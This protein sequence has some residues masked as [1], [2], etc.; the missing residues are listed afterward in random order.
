MTTDPTNNPL[1]TPAFLDIVTNGWASLDNPHRV[2][3]FVRK[4]RRPRGGVN[5]GEM[6]QLTDGRGK[7]WDVA[8]SNE[9]LE[10]GGSYLDPQA[11]SSLG[12]QDGG[13]DG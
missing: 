12:I 4:Y 6:W 3:I 9:R 7:F 5:P 1:A 13:Q 10:V 2:G 8:A 11:R